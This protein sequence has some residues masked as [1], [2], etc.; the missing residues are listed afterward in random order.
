MKAHKYELLLAAV[1]AARAT[2]FIFSKIVLQTMETFNLLAIRCLL[3]FFLLLIV[4]RK[5]IPQIKKGEIVAGIIVGALYYLTIASE[6]TALKTTA[7]STVA[8]LENCAIIFVPLFTSILCKKP[9]ESTTIISASVA[10]LGVFC[11]TAQFG[12]LS[13]GLV[14]GLLSAVLYAS[15]IIVTEKITHRELDPFCIGIVQVGTTA[16]GKTSKNPRGGSHPASA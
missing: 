3:A 9:L 15:A 1:I 13:P 6:L 5:K 12:G 10:M 8:L 16:G 4:F 11:L 7:S 14:F 2:S